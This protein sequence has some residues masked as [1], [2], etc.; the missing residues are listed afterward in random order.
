M[1][2]IVYRDTYS[3]LLVCLGLLECLGL[4][5]LLGQDSQATQSTIFLYFICEPGFQAAGP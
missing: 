1:I 4:L 2:P 5:H 3:V